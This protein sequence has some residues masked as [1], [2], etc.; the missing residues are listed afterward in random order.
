MHF[1]EKFIGEKWVVVGPPFLECS[2]CQFDWNSL[3]NFARIFY[4]ARVMSYLNI[5]LDLL[6]FNTIWCIGK[7][8]SY[9][10]SGKMLLRANFTMTCFVLCIMIEFSL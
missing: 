1:A 6:F 5:M 8:L 10:I 3:L 4:G 2:K 7:N 9:G